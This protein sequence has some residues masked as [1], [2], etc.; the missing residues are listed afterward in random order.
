MGQFFQ[1]KQKKKQPNVLVGLYPSAANDSAIY[2]D[3]PLYISYTKENGDYEFTNLPSIPFQL[4]TI[5]DNNKNKIYDGSEEEIGFIKQLV[6]ATDTIK[7]NLLLFKENAS[8]QF[9]KKTISNEY[10]KVS[11]IYNKACTDLKTVTL[12]ETSQASYQINTLQDSITIY[13]QNTFDTL[14]IIINRS[15]KNDTLLLKIPSRI[16]F[17]K[18]KKNNALKYKITSNLSQS[19]PYYENINLSL[20]IPFSIENINEA[21]IHLYRLNDSIKS[22]Q[23]YTITENENQFNSFQIKTSLEKENSYQLI[24]NKGAFTDYTVRT[25][26]SLNF[27]FRTT[28]P[29]DYAQLN[30]NLVFPRKENYIVLLLND[31]SQVV[32]KRII[33]ISLA[34][35]NEK[36]IAFINIIP[37]MYTI[38]VIED[39]NKNNRFDTGNFLYHIQAETIF[40]NET[41]L[42]LLAGWEIENDWIVK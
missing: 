20:N 33:S 18:L 12:L 19:F 3:K 24:I 27:N 26:D 38:K 11:V 35:T 15:S 21:K 40:V 16:D 4:M 42:K 31:K 22:K 28:T 10:G 23:T 30:L 2:K 6:T 9:L 37:G 39:A 13:Y 41:P 1:P 8:K 17:E 32:E 25:N 29:D 14:K 34:S 36:K 5:R 7:N